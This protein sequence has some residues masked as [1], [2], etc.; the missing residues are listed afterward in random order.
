MAHTVV[1]NHRGR[2]HH[3]EQTSPSGT[4]IKGELRS[5][6]SRAQIPRV[7]ERT[8]LAKLVKDVQPKCVDAGPVTADGRLGHKRGGLGG[9]ARTGNG[10]NGRSGKVLRAQ[11]T[12]WALNL[13]ETG[14][15]GHRGETL[16]RRTLAPRIEV[17]LCGGVVEEN[18]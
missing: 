8:A 13:E 6:V 16:G 4:A 7:W 2:A 12:L 9:L 10:P 5:R 18:L 14:G 17:L 1:V 3:A 11:G 15:I